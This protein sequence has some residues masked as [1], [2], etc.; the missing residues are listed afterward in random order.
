[1]K[2]KRYT[3]NKEFGGWETAR[4]CNRF[5]GALISHHATYKEALRAANSLR[6]ARRESA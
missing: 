1:M 4:W 5:C 6:D 3:I 2:D